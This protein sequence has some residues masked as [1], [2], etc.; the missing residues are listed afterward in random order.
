MVEVLR[1]VALRSDAAVEVMDD[2]QG[3]LGDI[4][5]DDN[6]VVVEPSV[7]VGHVVSSADVL[8]TRDPCVPVAH[9]RLVCGYDLHGQQ[10]KYF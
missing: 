2:G 5:L 3:V 1:G 6:C 9:R 7:L 8:Y 4:D 10:T